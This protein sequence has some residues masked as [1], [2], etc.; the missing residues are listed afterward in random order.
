[1]PPK[2][3]HASSLCRAYLEADYEPSNQD[4]MCGRGGD[5][6]FHPGNIAF[7]EILDS[8]KERYFASS[9]KLEKSRVVVEILQVLREKGGENEGVKFIRFDD[10]QQRW[11]TLSDEA[12]KQKIG[13][14]IRVLTNQFDHKE[15]KKGVVKVIGS[16]IQYIAEKTNKHIIASSVSD[17]SCRRTQDKDAFNSVRMIPC[18][19]RSTRHDQQPQPVTE[20][21]ETTQNIPIRSCVSGESANLTSYET[22]YLSE[23]PSLGSSADWFTV[24]GLLLED[25]DV[26]DM[27][28]DIFWDSLSRTSVAP[29]KF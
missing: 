4:I 21:S 11:Y 8:K 23:H 29:T 10:Q 22:H 17:S 20:I 13:Q 15:E 19:F 14:S 5:F 3:R 16:A 2:S 7:R 25:S 26:V 1:M 18:I 12:A 9:S 24:G 28:D 27:I 6:F